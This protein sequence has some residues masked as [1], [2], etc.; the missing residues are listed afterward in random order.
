MEARVKVQDVELE[1]LRQAIQRC[2]A[3]LFF[4]SV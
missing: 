3:F 4:T 2:A 1:E